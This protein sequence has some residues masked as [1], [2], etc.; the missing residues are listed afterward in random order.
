M[1]AVLLDTHAWVWSFASPA[2]L[3]ARASAAIT[4]ADT[5]YVS[6]ISFFEIGQKVRLGKWPEMEAHVAGLAEILTAQ[7]G[8]AAPFTPDICLR[9]ALRDWAHRDPFDRLLAASANVLGLPLVSRDAA[10]AGWNGLHVV[11]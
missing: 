8:V 1:R 2:L 9:A 4:G 7:G 3:S 11:W 10:F 5:V 6:P